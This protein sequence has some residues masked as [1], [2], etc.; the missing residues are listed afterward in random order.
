MKKSSYDK[1]GKV[2]VQLKEKLIELKK[3]HNEKEKVYKKIE[4]LNKNGELEANFDRIE[5]ELKQSLENI[6]RIAKEIKNLRDGI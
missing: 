3:F 1:V 5:K 2:S 6:E 4:I